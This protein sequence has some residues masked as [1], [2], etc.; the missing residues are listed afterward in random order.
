[1][2]KCKECGEQ[3]EYYDMCY[4]CCDHSDID[5]DERGCLICGKDMTEHCMVRAEYE[6]DMAEDR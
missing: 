4:E 3:A 1:M 6:R 5:Y 2:T